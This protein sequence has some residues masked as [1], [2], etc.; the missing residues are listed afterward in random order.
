MAVFNLKDVGHKGVG[1]E[2]FSEVHS[3]PTELFALKKG[4]EEEV[5]ETDTVVLLLNSVYGHRVF[6]EF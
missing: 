6:N 1:C 5:I 2:R 3:C 4:P